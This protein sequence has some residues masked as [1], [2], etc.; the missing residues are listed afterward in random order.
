VTELFD[1]GFARLE[2]LSIGGN[3]ITDAALVTLAT[4]PD[5]LVD[6]QLWHSK[7]TLGGVSQF[8]AATGLALDDSMRTSRGTYMLRL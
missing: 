8:R 3:G 5:Q 1:R 4:L 6:V 7:V 2:R